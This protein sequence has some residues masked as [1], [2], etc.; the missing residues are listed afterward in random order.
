MLYFLQFLLISYASTSGF[1]DAILWSRQAADAFGWNEHLVFVLE[2][3]LV[4]GIVVAAT[5]VSSVAALVEAFV[6]CLTFS[7]VHNQSYYYA[8]H[9]IDRS[10]YTWKMSSSTSTA[11]LDF[12]YTT[13][14]VLFIAGLVALV[15]SSVT[16]VEAK[17]PRRTHRQSPNI[18]LDELLVHLPPTA[19][20]RLFKLLLLLGE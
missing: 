20:T 8:R 2:R 4:L 7:F 9:L 11:K 17:P 6:F 13:R 12:G 16:V 14:L 15:L 18:P 5:Q 3:L 1:K 10:P 19:N